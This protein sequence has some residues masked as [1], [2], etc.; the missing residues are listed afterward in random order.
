MYSW[1]SANTNTVY[2]WPAFMTI[3]VFYLFVATRLE[4][5][6]DEDTTYLYKV[7]SYIVYYFGLLTQMAEYD[8]W[9]GYQES[10]KTFDFVGLSRNRHLALRL[11]TKNWDISN[12]KWRRGFTS[13]L[14]I[15]T[16]ILS[17]IGLLHKLFENNTSWY[18]DTR[19]V[20]VVVLH[21]SAT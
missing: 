7:Q 15:L 19:M 2:T 1:A 4:I 5:P 10:H 11:T 13:G 14:L 12:L 8:G 16:G 6:K 18:R 17:Q 20:Q 3:P 21:K 9:S